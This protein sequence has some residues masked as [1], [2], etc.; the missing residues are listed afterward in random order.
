MR[1]GSAFRV[2]RHTLHKPSSFRHG[3]GCHNLKLSLSLV[4]IFYFFAFF[5]VFASFFFWWRKVK[6]RHVPT[7]VQPV[8]LPPM[9]Q[10]GNVPFQQDNV[11][12]PYTRA[13]E[14]ALQEVRQLLRSAQLPNLSPI[15][16]LNMYWKLRQS[17]NLLFSRHKTLAILRQ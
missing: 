17:L 14:H 9:H 15:K 5:F 12:P 16:H 6:Q 1:A 8:Q 4:F 13:T 2:Y 10:E 11:L 3:F 7:V